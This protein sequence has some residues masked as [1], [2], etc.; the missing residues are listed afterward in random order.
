MNDPAK[1]RNVA[2]VGHR[3]TGK[4][5]LFEGLLFK[6]GVANRLGHVTEGTT[7]SDWDEDEKRRQ[8]SLSAALAHVERDG[9]TFNLIDTPG[10]SS[11]L[12]DAIASLQ[13]VETALVV[14]NAV[15]GVEVQTERLWARAADRGLAR[16]FFCN[17]L[18]R[19]RADFA[20]A[21]AAL[22]EVFG[23]QVVAV[24][25]PIG[26]EHELVGVVDL[27]TMKAFTYTDGKTQT[28]DVPADLA[29]AV[30]A[31]RDKLV[32]AVASTNDEL[33]EK[34][35]TEEEIGEDELKR[36]SPTASPRGRS[37]PSPPAPRRT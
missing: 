26:S 22:Q 1:I 28:G 32:D 24:H 37:T 21:V 2:L 27:L 9:L 29:D 11:F 15:L 30:A 34:Y 23:Q 36:P 4:T 12:A 8:L 31:A 17:M 35:L 3:G 33:A 10:D 18:D 14:V 25:L 20:R 13:V 7:I 16:L 5:S 19:E 6:A